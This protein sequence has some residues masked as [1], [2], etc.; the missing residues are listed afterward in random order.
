[1][2]QS[3]AACSLQGGDQVRMRM[4]ESVDGDA[5][6]E[7]EIA[8]PFV[9][10]EVGTFAAVECDVRPVIGRATAAKSQDD[11]LPVIRA[12]AAKRGFIRWMRQASSGRSGMRDA[13]CRARG[14]FVSDTPIALIAVNQ[15]LAR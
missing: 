7:I 8:S 1:M 4:A 6:A 11:L 5:G 9:V 3:F 13:A 12:I 10:E 2:C 14:V 15:F